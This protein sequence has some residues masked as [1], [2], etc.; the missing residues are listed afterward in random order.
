MVTLRVATSSHDSVCFIQFLSSRSGKSSRA[1]APRLSWR[2]SAE[3]AVD[4]DEFHELDIP[5]A[6]G[7]RRVGENKFVFV[8]SAYGLAGNGETYR[9]CLSASSKTLFNLRRKRK[10]AVKGK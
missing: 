2:L 10:F 3:S 6:Q 7:L 9:H 8:R 5:D 1:F 4:I